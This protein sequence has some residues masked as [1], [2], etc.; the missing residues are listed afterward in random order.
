MLLILIHYYCIFGN[1]ARVLQPLNNMFV[2]PPMM[3]LVRLSL[4]C[5]YICMC[6]LQVKSIIN[7]VYAHRNTV[8]YRFESARQI[9]CCKIIA[10]N[11]I[12]V[13]FKNTDMCSYNM[14]LPLYENITLI[15]RAIVTEWT[16]PSLREGHG[17]S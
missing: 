10:G 11:T 17:W 14:R 5:T 7:K 9:R 8:I 4:L 6:F 3:L 15:L 13:R 2:L 1:A 12:N 16:V